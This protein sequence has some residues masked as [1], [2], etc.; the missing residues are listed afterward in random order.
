M[1]LEICNDDA[2]K[3]KK[4]GMIKL[5]DNKTLKRLQKLS[6]FI[7]FVTNFLRPSVLMLFGRS[8]GRPRALSSVKDASTP[9]ARDT[10]KRTV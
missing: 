6:D 7:Y 2:K 3:K 10:P 1:S 4:T 9:I 5:E 8:R